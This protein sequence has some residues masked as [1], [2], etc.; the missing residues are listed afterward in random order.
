MK[1]QKLKHCS[2]LLY[3]LYM[4]NKIL[5][6]NDYNALQLSLPI[7]L[8]VKIDEDDMVVFFLKALEGVN[9]SKYFKKGKCR[10]RKE[11][12]RCKPVSYTHLD[13]YKR[14]ILNYIKHSQSVFMVF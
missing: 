13:V 3:N 9:L 11:Y 4:E 1:Q 8:G 7:D 10:E 14:Q 5:Q 12:D 6:Q 2:F